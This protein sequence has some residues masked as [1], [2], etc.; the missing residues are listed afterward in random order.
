[1]ALLI[2][3]ID[4]SALL[5]WL[6]R[7]AFLMAA[8]AL[9]YWVSAYSRPPGA[10]SLPLGHLHWPAGVALA[11]FMRY[12]PRVW[13]VL[14]IGLVIGSEVNFPLP[15]YANTALAAID[16]GSAFAASWWLKRQGVE[17]ASPQRIDLLY[18]TIAAFAAAAIAGVLTAFVIPTYV[19]WVLSASAHV[20]AWSLAA[21]LLI[22]PVGATAPHRMIAP[23]MVPPLVVAAIGVLAARNW[24]PTAQAW[25]TVIAQWVIA[26][27]LAGM[28]LGMLVWLG[29]RA[30]D[31][32]PWAAL[33]E[34][35]RMGIASWAPEG[36]DAYT[37]P[38][39]RVLLDDPEGKR[40]AGSVGLLASTH[41][42]DRHAL[43][44]TLE[45]LASPGN[46]QFKTELRMLAGDGW[47][48]FELCG[49]IPSRRADGRPT[50]V[51]LAL[52]DVT[53]RR[54]AADREH[55]SAS[56]F[57]HLHEG[58][59]IT[60]AEMRVLDVNPTYLAIL[61]HTRQ[62]LM[63]QIPPL[64]QAGASD[65]AMRAQHAVM[66]SSL[67]STGTWRGELAERRRDGEPCILQTTIT[68]VRG[69]DTLARYHVLVISDITE[70]R[71][72]RDRLER[73]AH[74]GELTR[75]PNRAHLA[76]LLAEGMAA[77]ERDGCLL[78]VCYLD[79]DHFKPVND[80]LA[81]PRATACWSSWPG[82]CAAPCAATPCG[83]TGRRD[84]GATSL[85]CFCAPIRW[86][87]LAWPWSA[88]CAWRACPMSWKTTLNPSPS[89]RAL[90]PP[91]TPSTAATQTPSCVTPT[92][93]CMAPSKR[94]ATAI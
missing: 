89:P 71:R 13:P 20:L 34:S 17:M 52:D 29:R 70:Q 48:W 39:W 83:R 59:L 73:Q 19:D 64:L 25:T 65:S 51:V 79:L 24:I 7:C 35:A 56:L 92:T 11:A 68:A 87:K 41:E 37:S 58:L 2:E 63:G 27:V 23:A 40:T 94:A 5:R 16:G 88:S 53:D 10:T 18:V 91:S 43:Q 30:R 74:Y 85:R 31:P 86:K 49:Q 44:L 77:T 36:H 8:C 26:A 69:P 93:P 50:R 84:W 21:L 12:G 38:R 66:W 33:F 6:G 57:Q 4:W 22:G 14:A 54:T 80:R 67:Q 60:D 81:T 42:E 46:D 28:T 76:Q 3:R 82:V 45:A 55:L 15:W 75:P 9:A 62:E 72:Q 78:A 32:A 61:G 1:M 90:A 47:R